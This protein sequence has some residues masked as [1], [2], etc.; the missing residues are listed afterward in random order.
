MVE[1]KTTM[2][3]TVKYKVCCKVRSTM[4]RHESTIE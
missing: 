4:G 2:D 3:K 1:D